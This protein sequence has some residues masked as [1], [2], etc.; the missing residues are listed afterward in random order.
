MIQDEIYDQIVYIIVQGWS[1][2]VEYV[3]FSN[4]MVIYWFYWKFFFFGEKDLNVVVS[5]FEVCYCVY[6]DYYVCI[7]GFDV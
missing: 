5:E 2:F 4:F 1:L 3:Y 6:F 7:V